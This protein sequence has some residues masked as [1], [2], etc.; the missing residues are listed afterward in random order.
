[1]SFRE[2]YRISSYALWIP[3]GLV[4][5]FISCFHLATALLGQFV[6]F[7]QSVDYLLQVT[8]SEHSFDCS[9]VAADFGRDIEE[10]T[11]LECFKRRRRFRT[12]QRLTR[13]KK[14]QSIS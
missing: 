3:N 13:K 4:S 2:A 8:T 1:V 5:A 14:F 11:I 12:Q 6:P 7:F 10:E 9:A